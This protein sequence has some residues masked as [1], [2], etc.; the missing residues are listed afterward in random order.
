MVIALCSVQGPPF[1]MCLGVNMDPQGSASPIADY[2]NLILTRAHHEVQAVL[3]LSGVIRDDKQK[4]IKKIK[5][6]K[7][8]SCMLANH[9]SGQHTYSRYLSNPP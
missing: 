6:G 2:P 1:T 8:F 9:T 3:V 4:K 7:E 5:K